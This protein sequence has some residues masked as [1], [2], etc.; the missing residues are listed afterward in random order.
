MELIGNRLVI[1][2]VDSIL[3]KSSSYQLCDGISLI[4]L[5]DEYLKRL[6]GQKELVAR[7]S[8][9][10]DHMKCALSVE[11]KKLVS[12]G[13]LN[14]YRLMELGV[15]LSM[16][17]RLATGVPIDIPF[18]FD[19]EG[20]EIKG[21][22]NTLVQTFRHGNRYTYPLDDGKQANGFMALKNGIGM[23]AQKHIFDSNKNVLVR[24]IEFS[25]VGFQT[26]HI[27]TRLVN[28]TIFL[29]S[30]F[31]A[32]NNE[33]AFQIAASVSWYLRADHDADER[34]ELFSKVKKLYGYRS[35]VVHGAD[36]SSKNKNLVESLLFGEDLNSEIFSTI[37]EKGHVPIF[38]AKQKRRQEELKQLV[39]GADCA[40]RKKHS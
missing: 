24:A 33:I 28:S 23:V 32:S 1:P 3:S 38:S 27:P 15:F 18:W 11:P 29:E 34:M 10:L 2:L 26:R 7:Y 22:G 13:P 19:C 17:I 8:S 21:Y 39:L 25:G 40:L 30:L 20:D 35:M 36:I 5:S 6:K 9:S 12:G 31:S 4:T 14:F 37:L 16:S